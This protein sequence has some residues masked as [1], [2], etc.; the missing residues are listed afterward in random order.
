VSAGGLWKARL[1]RLHD[2]MAR[3]VE[4]G[5]VL[6]DVEIAHESDQGGDDPSPVRAI[7]RVNSRTGVR[8]V[9]HER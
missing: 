3:Y 6:G 1:G 2:V 7:D 5:R 8:S 9:R 4:L